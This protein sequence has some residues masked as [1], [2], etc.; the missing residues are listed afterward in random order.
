MIISHEDNLPKLLTKLIDYSNFN[1]FSNAKAVARR[2]P[3]ACNF[4]KKET[5]AQ[6]FSRE[7]CEIFRNIFFNR[8]PLVAAFSNDIFSEPLL[9]NLSHSLRHNCNY[10]FDHFIHSCNNL[11]DEYAP[12]KK[13]I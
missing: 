11:L 10:D 9:K 13:G 8:I 7:F 4:I 1:F 3:E 6:A 12:C 5:L 2:C